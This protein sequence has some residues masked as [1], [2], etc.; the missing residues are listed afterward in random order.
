MKVAK[1]RGFIT[2]GTMAA[3][4][5]SSSIFFLFIICL[6]YMFFSFIEIFSNICQRVTPMLDATSR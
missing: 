4:V 5:I 6:K 1:K 2:I 3:M